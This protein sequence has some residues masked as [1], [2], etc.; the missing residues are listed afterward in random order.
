[1]TSS[2]APVQIRL[3]HDRDHRLLRA[4]AEAPQGLP[5]DTIP[6]SRGPGLSD[7]CLIVALGAGRVVGAI[8]MDPGTGVIVGPQV[9][10]HFPQQRIGEQLIVAA[11]RVAARYGRFELQAEPRG[12]CA[13]LLQSLG[14]QPQ[15]D[16]LQRRFPRRRTRFGRSIAALNEQLGLPHDYGVR[17]RLPLQPEPKELV[18]AG[19]DKF[20]RPQQMTVLAL[21]A[22]DRMRAAAALDGVELQL[23]SAFRSVRYQ[24]ELIQRKLDDGQAI[25][26]ILAVSAAPG[27]SEHHSGAALDLTTPGSAVLEEEFASTAAYAWLKQHAASHG[28]VESYPENNRHR[29]SYEPWHWCHRSGQQR[30][31]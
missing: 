4:L 22:W 20:A 14:Y 31:I 15:G 7:R 8:T 19:P 25:D 1:M 24:A 23:V 16:R 17:H 9:A 11:E 2:P 18:A 29:I 13:K 28:F 5:I 3:D 12:A 21:R 30:H 27:Y 26:Q 6:R 10:R